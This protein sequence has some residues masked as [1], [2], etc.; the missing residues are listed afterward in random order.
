VNNRYAESEAKVR[1]NARVAELRTLA[2]SRVSRDFAPIAKRA[3]DNARNMRNL[4]GHLA[5]W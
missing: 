5:P 1:D 4:R 2:Q 3:S